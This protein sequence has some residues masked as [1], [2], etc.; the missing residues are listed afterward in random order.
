MNEVACNCA[1]GGQPPKLVVLTGGPGAGKSAVLEIVRRT[2]CSHVAVLPEAATVLFG[3]G[4]P[5]HSSDA[6]RRHA[7][8]AILQ[9]QREMEL[10]YGDERSVAVALC[11]RGTLDG[12]AYYPGGADA[13]LADVGLDRRAELAR[14]AAVIHLRTPGERQGYDHSNAVRLE[15]A[16]EARAIDARIE[17]A[18]AGHSRRVFVESTDDFLAKVARAVSLIREELPPCCRRHPVAELGERAPP[19]CSCHP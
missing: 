13:L 7:Q 17:A 2:L 16:A 5:R 6:G 10:L 1:V 18:W 15:S 14:Y 11:D 8:R 9:V 12:G 4:F 19:G 3:G